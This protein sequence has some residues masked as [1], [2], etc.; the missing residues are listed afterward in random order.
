MNNKYQQ[1]GEEW[2]KVL[3]RAS[4]K[5]LIS[6]YKKSCIENKN[7]KLLVSLL[8]E[9]RDYIRQSNNNLDLDERESIEF[10]RVFLAIRRENENKR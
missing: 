5:D 8:D 4:R 2:E 1:F 3:M 9:I 6:L 10:V 7:I